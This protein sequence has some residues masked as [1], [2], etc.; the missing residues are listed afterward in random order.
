MYHLT[1]ALMQ[2][3]G[4]D[5]LSF[6]GAQDA[7]DYLINFINNLDPNGQDLLFWPQ[8]SAASPQLL[9]MLDGGS[10]SLNLTEDTYRMDGINLLTNLS[11]Q[12]P[13]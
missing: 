8:Y 9:T 10:T 7:R 11:L 4:S 12:F 6:Y 5:L 13:L 2:F 1:N 3:H